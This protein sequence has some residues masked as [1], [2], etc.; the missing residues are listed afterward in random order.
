MWA[1][2]NEWMEYALKLKALRS[3]E[4]LVSAYPTARWHT[5]DHNLSE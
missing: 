2:D 5:P 1:K 3:S 4:T